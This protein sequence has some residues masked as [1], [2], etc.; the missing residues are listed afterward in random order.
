MQRTEV[1]E[2]IR[3][4]ILLSLAAYAYEFHDDAIISDAEFDALSL[5]IRPDMVTGNTMLD[6][7]FKEEFNA[8]TGMWIRKHPEIMKLHHIYCTVYKG[9]NK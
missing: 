2:E 6:I 5:K 1:E 9:D 3:N 4:R 8:A 7:F